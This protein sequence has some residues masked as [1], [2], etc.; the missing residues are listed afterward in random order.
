VSRGWVMLRQ[1]VFMC[2][3]KSDDVLGDTVGE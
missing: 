2:A 3:S 1:V